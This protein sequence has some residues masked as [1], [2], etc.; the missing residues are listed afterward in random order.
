MSLRAG[1]GKLWQPHNYDRK[2]HGLVPLYKAL[3]KSYNLAT[4]NLGLELGVDQVVDMLEALG[5]QRAVDRCR[6]CCWVRSP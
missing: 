2:T 3:A 5:V 1:D 4:V 6:P